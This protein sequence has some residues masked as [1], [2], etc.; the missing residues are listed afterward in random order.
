MFASLAAATEGTDIGRLSNTIEEFKSA[1]VPNGTEPLM[2]AEKRLVFLQ[3][4]KGSRFLHFRQD[5]NTRICL[6]S[7]K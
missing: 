6:D 1:Q 7:N 3:L 5:E 2:R 4:H